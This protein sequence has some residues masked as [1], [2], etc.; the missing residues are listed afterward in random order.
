M[1][2]GLP[3]KRSEIT[4]LT[5]AQIKTH[6]GSLTLDQRRQWL[7]VAGHAQCIRVLDAQSQPGKMQINVYNPNEP[8]S[9]NYCTWVTDDIRP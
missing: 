2:Y 5:C 3:V 9:F 6:Y 7:N 1:L 8:P 4:S